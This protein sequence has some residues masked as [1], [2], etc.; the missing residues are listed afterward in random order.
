MTKI[1][2]QPHLGQR[3]MYNV[4]I[5]CSKI[6]QSMEET[7]KAYLYSL[8]SCD[9]YH[10][11]LYDLLDQ[12]C[13]YWNWDKKN[14]TIDQCN[15]FTQHPEYNLLLSYSTQNLVLAWMDLNKQEIKS[16][17]KEKY[18]GMFIGRADASRIRA[19][20]NHNLFEFKE[21]GL[22]S[23]NDDLFNYMCLPELFNY[24]SDSK[25]TYTEMLTMKTPYSDIDT[26][27]APPITPP[28][29]TDAKIWSRVYERIGIEIICETNLIESNFDA[30]EKLFRPMYYKKPFLVISAPDFLPVARKIYGIKT[31]SDIFPETYDELGGSLRVD[32]VFNVLKGIITS[33]LIHELEEKC[34]E[35]TEHNYNIVLDMMQKDF[36]PKN[37]EDYAREKNKR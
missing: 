9:N 17:N 36:V 14:I 8:E 4:G 27:M 30:T 1:N 19:L 29:N 7:G 10:T 32:E 23:F 31:F 34:K 37:I 6:I 21:K 18:Y 16:W 25:Q 35:I 28:Y 33:G 5:L 15:P 12:L 11:G 20:Y 3:E 26:V 2:I 22:T 24:L 13:R